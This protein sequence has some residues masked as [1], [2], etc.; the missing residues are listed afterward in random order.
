MHKN[1][2]PSLVGTKKI[3]LAHEVVVRSMKPIRC[4]I[5]IS[6]FS[7]NLYFGPDIFWRM[8]RQHQGI[9]KLDAVLPLV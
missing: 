2:V 8:Y 9:C 3:G 1:C 6:S 5:S 7:K 4:V